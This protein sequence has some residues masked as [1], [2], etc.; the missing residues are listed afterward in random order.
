MRANHEKFYRIRSFLE[1]EQKDL[2]LMKM[3]IGGLGKD[4]TRS[5]V[6]LYNA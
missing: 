1:Q 5:L 4:E 2:A 3:I 6:R